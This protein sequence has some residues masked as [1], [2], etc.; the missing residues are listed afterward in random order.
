MNVAVMMTKYKMSGRHLTRMDD[1]LLFRAASEASHI[2]GAEAKLV[3][4]EFLRY[5]K[6]LFIDW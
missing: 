6:K 1:V 4:F 5:S 3:H 2:Q